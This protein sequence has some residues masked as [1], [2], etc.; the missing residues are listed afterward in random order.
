MASLLQAHSSV[1]MRTTTENKDYEVFD[2]DNL[3]DQYVE[4]DLLQSFGDITADPSSSN[5]LAHLFELP[6]SNGGD[7][8]ETSLMPDWQQASTEDAWHR[9]L[10]PPRQNP[11][12]PT[13]SSASLSVYPESR[14]KVSLSNPELFNSD[15]HFEL[16]QIIPRLSLSTPST[17][18]A[19]VARSPMK[20]VTSPEYSN[21]NGIQKSSRRS[22]ISR[23]AEMMRPSQY[24]TG[25][26]DFLSRKIEDHADI[27]NLQLQPNGIPNSPLLSAK[28]GQGEHLDDFF[29][30]DQSYTIPM[31]HLQ[32][33]VTTPDLNYQLTP[34]SSP[35]DM[36]SRNRDG[37]PL[38]FSSDT[39]ISAHVSSHISHA[40][41]SALQTRPPT[42]RQF[43]GPWGPDEAASLDFAISASPDFQSSNVGKTAGWR[44]D[45][46]VS[47]PPT[48]T[49]NYLTSRSRSASQSMGGFMNESHSLAGLGISCDTA[50][51]SAFGPELHPCYTNMYSQEYSFPIRQPRSNRHT[52]PS[53]RSP[54]PSPQP[55]FTRRRNSSNRTS[56]TT[57]HHRKSSISSANQSTGRTSVGFVNFTPDD[58]KK[59]LTGVAPSG[60]SKTKAR[61]EKEAADKRR[62]LSQAAVKAVIEAGGD[63]ARLEKEG[64][65]VMDG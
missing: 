3:F 26:H 11:A 13:L 42:H 9:T 35:I 4:T 29:P 61:R 14:G 18:K 7:S 58:S 30:Q 65:L 12:S 54:S 43:T 56:A 51:F 55:H 15:D 31:S 62:R 28:L 32:R 41:L 17:P 36:N 59:I 39:M 53:S 38:Q 5:D 33:D 27:F 44:N 46:H 20:T 45:D 22:T 47:Q 10:Q 50:S 19:Q 40:G 37:N 2:L 60:S 8:F 6:S 21:R 63:L 16:D 23:I 24:R 25:L 34:L 52:S 64:L 1:S 48:P 57:H 49:P